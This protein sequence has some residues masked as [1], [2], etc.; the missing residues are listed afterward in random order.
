MYT[1]SNLSPLGFSISE[2]NEFV[3]PH[4]DGPQIMHRNEFGSSGPCRFAAGFELILLSIF[5]TGSER[6]CLMKCILN[7]TIEIIIRARVFIDVYLEVSHHLQSSCCLMNM[8]KYKIGCGL[9]NSAIDKLPFEL[10]IP[11]YQY[12]GP[13]TKLAKRL[14]RGDPGINPLDAACKVHDIAYSN[15]KGDKERAEADRIL[16]S[17]AWRRVKSLDAGF[18]ERTTALAVA[19]AMKAKFGLS[20]IG[21]GLKKR[22]IHRK[23]KT[24]SKKTSKK[25]CKI[26]NGLRKKRS[27]KTGVKKKKKCCT[28]KKM[29]AHTK[30]ALKITKPRTADDILDTAMIAAK[31]LGRE[32]N[33]S[34]PRIVPIPKTG[35]VLP[36]VPIFAGLSA[37]GSLAGGTAS[38]I[39]AIKSTDDGRKALKGKRAGN[40]IVGQGLYL[41]P[42]KQGYGLYLK[43]YSKNL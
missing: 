30:K 34:K 10:H 38:L 43:P 11:G 16:A 24:T 25:S 23:K 22:R 27:K 15:H 20:K 28:F 26:G 31:N 21:N 37:L 2:I 13:G 18:G 36:L 41:Q 12:C 39:R 9:I 6:R 14:A 1:F 32:K 35:G 42:Y 40:V 7:E 29:I 19:A 8:K 5:S 33:V 3:F 4:P 17:E